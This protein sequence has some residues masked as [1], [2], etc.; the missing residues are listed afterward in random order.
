M[1][2]KIQLDGIGMTSQRTRNRMVER[3]REQGIANVGVIEIMLNTPRHIFIEEGLAHK[4]YDDVSLPIGHGQTIS[5]PYIVARMT[6]LLL[7]ASP[8]KV[9]EI[10]T[11]SGYQ[12]AVLA[13]VVDQ[14]Y[15]VERIRPLLDK[16]K[17]KLKLLKVDNVY[18]Q[19]ADGG[20]GWRR[21]GPFDGILSA[22]APRQVPQELK[23][24]LAVGGRMVIPVGDGRQQHLYVIDRKEN[25]FV[26]K[27]V[28][29][30]NFV[31]LV[32][33]RLA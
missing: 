13:Q 27:V 18:F 12:T 30:V 20:E 22:A 32:S 16:A 4:A 3:L 1:V 31:P 26:E 24:Q 6:E 11:G 25:G 29:Q 17:Q 14:V 21:F 10:G 33:G 23:E 7:E 19:H 9:L 2:S 15:S 28:E 8:K 5:Q